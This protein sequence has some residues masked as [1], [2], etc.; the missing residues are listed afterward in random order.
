MILI[1]DATIVDGTGAPPQQK[2]LI[3]RKDR[4]SAVGNF[5][6][7]RAETVIKA[8]GSYLMPGFIDIHAASDHYL[9]LFTDPDQSDLLRQ[10]ITTIV[11]GP[12][13]SSLA[14]LLYGSLESIRKWTDTNAVNV[15][16][17]T[18]AEFLTVLQGMKLGVNFATL[19]GH[20][21]IRRALIGGGVRDLTVRELDVLS[22]VVETALAEGAFGVSTG[23]EFVHARATP[24]VELKRIA[25]AAARAH[26]LYTTH[27]RDEK[28]GL[29]SAVKEAIALARDTRVKTVVSHFRP[30][31][32]YESQFDAALTLLERAGKDLPVYFDTY[33]YDTSIQPIY[34]LL[35]AW[36]KT[37]DLEHMRASI[38]QPHLREAILRELPAFGDDDVVVASAPTAPFLLGKNI[39]GIARN[40]KISVREA[41]LTLMEMTGMRAV[42]FYKNVH[43][44]LA[45][46]SLQLPNALLGSNAPSV[47]VAQSA[48]HER[49][50]SA[51]LKFLQTAVGINLM[52]L[53]KA[54][55]KITSLPA[56]LVGFSDRGQV[57]ES[58]YADLTLM[59]AG[60]VTDVFVNGVHAVVNG[61]VTAARGG[62]PLLSTW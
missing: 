43:M 21:T 24:Y 29:V 6:N 13:G 55:E 60:A 17:H 8:R 4:I 50:Q 25:T 59:R 7:V 15:N 62:K 47:P 23:L 12:C 1:R 36:A 2:D 14:P 22:S 16:W 30:F 61:A 45:I 49:F 46:A 48:P 52:P 38:A 41:L 3:I 26:A 54:V 40:R 58:Y 32:G 9:T 28:D 37:G 27:V 42:V 56:R 39:G 51:F 35:P 11:G 33:P 19:A 5:A 53:E 57:K 10:G 20:S 18:I 31:V 44:D 34:T